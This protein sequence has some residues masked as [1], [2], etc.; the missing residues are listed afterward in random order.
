METLAA[1][2]SA[3]VDRQHQHPTG[4]VGRLIGE[5]MRHQ[6]A[7]E[8]DWTVELLGLEARDRVLELGFG[9]GRGLALALQDTPEG[10]VTG[11]DLSATMVRAAMRR[12]HTALLQGRLAVLQGDIA[13][14]PLRS[15]QFSKMFS[16][17]TLYFWR[18]PVLIFQQCLELLAPGGRLVVTCATGRMS[19]TG[20]WEYWPIHQQLE[21]LI[22]EIPLQTGALASL[23]YGPNSRQ[24]NNLA[25]VVDKP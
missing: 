16:I 9:A 5:R 25:I 24:F 3:Y 6:H 19:A 18:D 23:S 1:R 14:L 11:I 2:W 22:R 21:A 4:L 20:D 10:H 15:A 17:H 7:P 8:T 13:H 12:N